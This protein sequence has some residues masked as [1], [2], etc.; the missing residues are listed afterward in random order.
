MRMSW[1][2]GKKVSTGGSSFFKLQDGQSVRVRFLY[3]TLSEIGPISVH[4]IREGANFATIDCCRADGDPIDNCKWCAKGD[5]P[6]M[7]VV[8]PL[9]N[10]D[11]NEIQYWT[12]SQK[13]AEELILPALEEI[14]SNQPIAGQTFKIKRTGTEMKDTTYSVVA[15][16]GSVNDGKT[17][18]TFGEVKDPYE[19]NIIRPNDFEFTNNQNSNQNTA[20][21]NSY[22][23]TR[24]PNDTF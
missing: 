9:F 8:L 23:S 4:N 14:P 17:K 21:S 10:L 22:T 7:R 20:T 16:M 24:R 13:R 18:E 1:E 6:V 3:N 2:E 12:V 19:A 11:N 15:E 5:K